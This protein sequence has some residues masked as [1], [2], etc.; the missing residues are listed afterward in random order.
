M[1]QRL[2]HQ[3]LFHQ[4]PIYQRLILVANDPRHNPG[5]REHSWYGLWDNVLRLFESIQSSH[6]FPQY[7]LWLL[8]PE[9]SMPSSPAPKEPSSD[10][11]HVQDSSSFDT[12]SLFRWQLGRSSTA[13]TSPPSS[14]SAYPSSP[15]AHKSAPLASFP[16]LPIPQLQKATMSMP[17]SRGFERHKVVDFAIAQLRDGIH[18]IDNVVVPI[19]VEIKKYQRALNDDADTGS[20]QNRVANILTAQAQAEGQARYLFTA[21]KQPAVLAIAASGPYWRWAQ[22]FPQRHIADV[23]PNDAGYVPPD[24]VVQPFDWTIGYYT[25]GT[26]ESDV[27]LGRILQWAA[28]VFSPR[29]P[30]VLPIL[31][32]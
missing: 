21:K 9:E 8:K 1:D 15:L 6:V 13:M 4:R 17:P 18:A 7:P 5:L 3:R 25:I 28:L 16:S 19:I 24:D 30:T 22:L 31:R 27:M 29:P 23:D 10:G 14:P 2:I 11:P 20:R 26:H 32:Q 12:V